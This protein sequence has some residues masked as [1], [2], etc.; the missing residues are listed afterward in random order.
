M[1]LSSRGGQKARPGTILTPSL[2]SILSMLGKGGSLCRVRRLVFAL[3]TDPIILH[4]QT[5]KEKRDGDTVPSSQ[6]ICAGSFSLE[7]NGR[8]S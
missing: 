7:E 3:E 1:I 5:L 6:D 4:Y 2:Y 8:W